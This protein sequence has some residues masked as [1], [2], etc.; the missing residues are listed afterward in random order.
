[1]KFV[2]ELGKSSF[3]VSYSWLQR[4]NSRHNLYLKKLCGEA[5]DFDSS[6]SLK[7]WKDVVLLDILK[8]YEPANM[9]NT[10]ECR[11]Y[12][13]VPDRTL[14]FKGEKC[15][16]GKK[17]K[18]CLTMLLAANMGGS[19]KMIPLVIGKFLKPLCM[20]NC[21]FVPHFYDANLK[22]WMSANI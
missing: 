14:C 3:I 15:A 7:E 6:S 18:E 2:T 10:D 5:A 17:S 19:E 22:V 16:E 13:I 1:M 8:K 21:K 12:M 11:L 4:F 20:M 9:F